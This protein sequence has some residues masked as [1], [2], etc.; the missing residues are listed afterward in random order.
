MSNIVEGHGLYDRKKQHKERI[1][2][3][4]V[5][6]MVQR[7]TCIDSRLCVCACCHM[8]QH[9]VFLM[10]GYACGA[11]GFGSRG[12]TVKSKVHAVNHLFVRG[13]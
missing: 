12:F 4:V 5:V 1:R 6:T 11:E 8:V 2:A 3:L 9:F 7:V 10:E 13:P